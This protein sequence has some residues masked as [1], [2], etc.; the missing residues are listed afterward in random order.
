MIEKPS[1]FVPIEKVSTSWRDR[2][3]RCWFG[4][5]VE[6]KNIGPSVMTR[7]VEVIFAPGD[8]VQ[9]Q[10]CSQNARPVKTWSCQD[11]AQGANDTTA[12]AHQ[13]SPRIVTL[14]RSIIFRAIRPGKVLAAAQ[15]K[16][17]SLQRNVA[18]R[19]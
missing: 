11:L 19:G 5:D 14:N 3:R 12:A 16:T 9:I 8:L 2:Y 6:A 7:Y 13:D 4:I 17:A 1:L 15:D 18:H 10:L